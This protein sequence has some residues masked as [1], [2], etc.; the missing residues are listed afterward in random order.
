MDVT[1]QKE[2]GQR[3]GIT[4]FPTFKYF[5]AGNEAEVEAYDEGRDLDSFVN[6]LNKKASQAFLRTIPQELH[7]VRQSATTYV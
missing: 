6:F 7:V 2:L 1:G 5:P 4:G 3:F